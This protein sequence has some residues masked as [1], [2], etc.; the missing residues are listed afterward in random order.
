MEHLHTCRSVHCDLAARNCMLDADLNIKIGDFGLCRRVN[1]E[2]EAYEPSIKRRDVPF[3][4]MAPEAI[5]SE[6]VN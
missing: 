2:S 4:W 6:K 5:V 1:D 3:P